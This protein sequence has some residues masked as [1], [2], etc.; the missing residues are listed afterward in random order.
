VIFVHGCFWHGHDCTRGQRPSSN[1]EFWDRKL[2]KNQER[3]ARTVGKL[4]DAGWKVLTIWECETRSASE[5]ERQLV[6]FLSLTREGDKQI[7][8]TH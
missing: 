3:D 5:L 1:R 4:I 6:E 2:S 8:Q 7:A